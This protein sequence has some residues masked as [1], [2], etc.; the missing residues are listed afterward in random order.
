[1]KK[2]YFFLNWTSEAHMLIDMDGD[3][4]CTLPF[5]S[6]TRLPLVAVL[7]LIALLKLAFVSVVWRGETSVREW[8]ETPF[9]FILTL[10]YQSEITLQISTILLKK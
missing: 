5:C 4:F 2:K 1:M 6:G 7:D 9:S 8:K 10:F 3:E